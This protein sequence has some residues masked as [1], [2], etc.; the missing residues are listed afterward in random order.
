M[1]KVNLFMEFFN[2]A[3]KHPTI[4][5]FLM[6]EPNKKTYDQL[7]EYPLKVELFKYFQGDHELWSSR[8]KLI[9]DPLNTLYFVLDGD[10]FIT[11]D[12]KTLPLKNGHIYLIPTNRT[13]FF[14]C[15]TFIEKYWS[16]FQMRNSLGVDLLDGHTEVVCLSNDLKSI[17]HLFVDVTYQKILELHKVIYD[18]LDSNQILTAGLKRRNTT[19]NKYLKVFQL[20]ENHLSAKITT[21]SLAE[22]MG[23]TAPGFS[24]AFHRDTGQTI[25]SYVNHR[26]NQ[27]ACELILLTDLKV[28][29][30]A[31]ALDYEDEYYFI[32][33]FKKMNGI[34]PMQYR[35]RVQQ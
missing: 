9:K 26:L 11:F 5:T 23:M 10:G 20:L 34:P 15:K 14:G 18:L 31:H 1:D 2:M 22:S 27:K 35:I 6:D 24:R 28:K 21:S 13:R 32:R 25:K 7:K 4:H 30:I 33:F 17:Q 16:F 12:G 19:E 3:S 8:G 29:E